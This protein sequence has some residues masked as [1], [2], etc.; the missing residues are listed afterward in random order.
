MARTIRTKVYL[1]SELSEKVKQK[2]IND[3]YDINV[4]YEWWESA[5]EDAA[6]IGLKIGPHRRGV[7][8]S[9]SFNPL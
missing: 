3:N 4:D 2:V 9:T 6:N 7:N 8:P 1:F 5:Y